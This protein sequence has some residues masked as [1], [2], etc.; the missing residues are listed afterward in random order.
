[1]RF[2]EANRAFFYAWPGN[3]NNEDTE[4]LDPDITPWKLWCM[5]GEL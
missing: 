2:K 4:T 3:Y 5:G 1:M